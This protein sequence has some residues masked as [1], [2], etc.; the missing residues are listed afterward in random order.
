MARNQILLA[1]ALLIGTLMV[2]PEARSKGVRLPNCTRM[3]QMQKD[4]NQLGNLSSAVATT[5]FVA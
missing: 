1:V 4:L 2:V 3:L 5:D